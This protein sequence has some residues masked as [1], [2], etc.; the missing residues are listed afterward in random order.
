[1]T[2]LTSVRRRRRDLALLKALGF[3]RRQ[4][5]ELVA[6]QST[7]SVAIGVVIGLPLGIV[8]GRAMWDLFAHELFAIPDPTVPVLAT[9]L[10]AVGSLLLANLIAAIPGRRAANTSTSLLLNAE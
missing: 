1:L 7:V 2:L 8:F 5:S 3:T 4:L 6:W 9:G 10:V